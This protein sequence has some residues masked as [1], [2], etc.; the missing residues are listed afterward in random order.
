MPDFQIICLANSRKHS[1]RCIAGLRT[2]GKGWLRPVT[3]KGPLNRRHYLLNNNTETLVL[4]ILNINLTKPVPKNY[5]PE[6]WLIG[7]LPWQ[8]VTRPA[9]KGYIPI[10]K[11]FVEK[12]PELFGN[13]LDRVP[14]KQINEQPI[15]G[16][17]SLINPNDLSW[18]ITRSI[19]GNRQIRARFNLIGTWYNLVVTDSQ[20]EQNLKSF[21]EGFY[22][23]EKIGILENTEVLFTISLAGPF[24]GECFKLVAGI[25]LL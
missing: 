7:N 10:I 24:Q 5:Q 17:L 18:Q 14:I 3:S 20:I 19:R 6:N 13:T 8:L 15:Q 16:S 11:K 1:G 25:I 21:N 2:D 12:G 9:H 23:S 22:L 4:D